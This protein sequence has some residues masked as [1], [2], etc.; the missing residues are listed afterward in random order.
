MEVDREPVGITPVHVAVIPAG[1]KV[2][3]N[4]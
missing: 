3:S 1:V 2:V 4:M